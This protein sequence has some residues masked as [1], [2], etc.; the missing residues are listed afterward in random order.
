MRKSAPKKSNRPGGESDICAG[1]SA[2]KSRPRNLFRPTLTGG[3]A[4]VAA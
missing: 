3:F 4:Q 2:F 1:G